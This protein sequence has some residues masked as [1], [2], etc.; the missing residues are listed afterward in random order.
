MTNARY[1]VSTLAI[2]VVVVA[3]YF[4]FFNTAPITNYPSTGTDIVAFGDSLVAGTGSTEGHDFVSLLSGA[5]GQPVINLGVPGDTTQDGL[6]R[7]SEL[8]A[9]KPKVVLLLFG[10]NDYLKRIPQEQTFAN[11]AAIIKDI[12]GRGA[13][14]LLLG[15]RG[16]VFGDH[17]SGEFE[18]LRNT[19]H[20][21]YV[22]DVLGGLLGDK[23][24]MSDQVHPNDTGYRL[25][26]NRITPVLQKLLQ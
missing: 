22:P 15:V 21:A 14:V 25:M 19:Y 6:A 9:Y 2:L 24:Y 3:V 18:D 10:G 26:A 13:I 1:V 23:K 12:Q 8:D 7:M 4:F 17:F 5:I 11:L 20:T 16:G